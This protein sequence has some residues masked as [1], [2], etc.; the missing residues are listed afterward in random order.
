MRAGIVGRIGRQ[1][2]R[3]RAGQPAK[4]AFKCNALTDEVVIDALYRASQAGVPVD[5]WVRGM[6]ALKPGVPGLSETVRV[7]SILG[8]FL[9]HS[10]VYAFGAGN[11]GNAGNAGEAPGDA[12]SGAEPGEDPE[13]GDEVWL[14]SADMMHRNLDRRVETLVRVAD[15]GQCASLRNLLAR[16]M[17]DGTSSWWLDGNGDWIRH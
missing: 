13:A 2:A 3:A 11:A 10:R 14:G 15:P 17:D 9:E 16:G 7:R 8:R 1:A 5:I 12:D 6:C 4:I